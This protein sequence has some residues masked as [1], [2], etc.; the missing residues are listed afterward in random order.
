MLW[1]WER[2]ED[3][4]GID[5]R[6]AGVAFLARTVFLTGDG[7]AVRPRLQPL[8]VPP[9]TTV[10]AVVRVE[11]G[12]GTP[13]T[14]SPQQ[15]KATAQAI[16]EAAGTPRLF[17]LQVDFDATRSERAFYRDLLRDL[18][19]QLPAQMP[20]SITALASWCLGDNWLAGFPVDD[21]IPM[22]FRMGIGER[23]VELHL[24]AGGD[25]R[26]PVCRQS[27]GI[28][29]DEP[30]A[31]LPAGRRLYIFRPRAWTPDFARLTIETVQP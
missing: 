13:P 24:K 9:G 21:A 14:L 11:I 26:S 23:E 2:P 8:R 28:S 12:R 20:L 19:A 4:R 30:L 6:E 5:P 18:R 17:G 27:L 15:R 16:A 1:A 22:L 29:T 31:Y 10:V 25:F 7:V 3:L